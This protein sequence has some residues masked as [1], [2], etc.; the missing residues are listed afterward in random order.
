M[1]HIACMIVCY[2]YCNLCCFFFADLSTNKEL[3]LNT[4][5]I[6]L[7]YILVFIQLRS[8]MTYL[9]ISLAAVVII[10]S[11]A[12]SVRSEQIPMR[13][14]EKEVGWSKGAYLCK[15]SSPTTN[16]QDKEV[17]EELYYRM[18]GAVWV[19][20][21]G[22]M[23]GDPCG[24]QWYGICCSNTGRITELNMPSNL[25]LG[26][27][28]SR[29]AD[30]TELEALRLFNNSIEGVIP[31]ELF[32]MEKLQI[33]DLSSNFFTAALPEKISMPSLFNL[34]LVTNHLV[35]YLPSEWN[36]PELS[37]IYLASNSFQGSIPADMGTLTKLKELDVSSNSLSG[38]TANLGKLKSLEKLWLFGNRFEDAE[39]PE[40][41][42]GM[43]G[44]KEIRIDGLNG[45]LPELIGEG[46]SQIIK[47]SITIG[48]INGSLPLSFC[49]F[50][51]VNSI[52]LS[53]NSISGRIPEC[54]CDLPSSSLT[55]IDLSRNQL[56]GTIP[57]CFKNLQNL[58]SLNFGSNKLT[59]YLPRSLGSLPHLRYLSVGTNELYG[60]VPTEYNK[61]GD[62]IREFDINTNKIN[63]IEDDLEPFFKAFQE[64][65]VYCDLYGNPWTCP[66]PTF[67]TLFC[68][69]ECSKC[70]TPDKHESCTSCVADSQCGWCNEGGNCLPG[71]SAGPTPY[72]YSCKN[73]SWVYEFQA[74]CTN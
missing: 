49:K 9:K 74:K 6:W 62:S 4:P 25:V 5:R 31:Q 35:G 16:Q 10:C 12:L 47:L 73:E 30:L 48:Q 52:D 61:L 43:S 21:E 66:L 37:Y 29:I 7:L 59:G 34:T 27:L 39:I 46:W 36:A 53:G 70:N 20:S 13:Q 2:E 42:S 28:T 60:S 50:K 54:I 44:L 38:L 8:N 22:W 58:T 65:G 68:F 11:I 69:I 23:K 26:Q 71:S 67:V 33:L 24:D 3:N 45:N 55:S 57:D 56:S 63:S 1:N 18:G 32:T 41:W 64:T 40:E 19:K 15:F 17:L 72:Y 51:T 14:S